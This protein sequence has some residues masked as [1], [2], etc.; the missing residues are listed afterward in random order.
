MTGEEKLLLGCLRGE[1]DEGL[2]RS[3]DWTA[4]LKLAEKHKVVP[5]VNAKAAKAPEE[6]RERLARRAQEILFRNLA[7]AGELMG[8]LDR[9]ERAGIRALPIKGPVLAETVYGGIGNRQFEDL[10]VLVERRNLRAAAALLAESGYQSGHA[11]RWAGEAV[12][13][14]TEYHFPFVHAKRGISVELHAEIAPY[15][16]GVRLPFGELCGRSERRPLAGRMAASLSLEDTM[17]LVSVHG[18]KHAWNSLD[19][20]RGAALLARRPDVD[21]RAALDRARAAGAR[22]MLLLGVELARRLAGVPVPEA[23]RAAAAADTAAVS[24]LSEAVSGFG[25]SGPAF[26]SLPRFH[27]GCCERWRDRV[28]YGLR[29]AAPNADELAWLPLPR[30]L[31][32]LYW[33]LRPVRAAAAYGAPALRWVRGRPAGRR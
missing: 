21:W 9:F 16:L 12:M 14:R 28:L 26:F 1:V 23:L 29:L 17:L 5:L 22:R 8:L 31:F 7:L 10:D 3:A 15:Y 33:A 24:A 32:P 19:M 2:A 18:A 11:G 6:V 13:L 30:R 27:L 20:V 4:A 25:L